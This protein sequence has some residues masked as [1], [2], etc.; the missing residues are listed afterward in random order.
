MDRQIDRQTGSKTDRQTDRGEGLPHTPPSERGR[1]R[2]GE[3]ELLMYFLV[4]ELPGIFEVGTLRSEEIALNTVKSE[5]SL[6][7]LCGSRET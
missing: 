4:S 6:K 1:G 3:R 2:R 7:T 5:I